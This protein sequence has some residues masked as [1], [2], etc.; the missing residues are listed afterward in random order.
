VAA[1]VINFRGG[2]DS[3]FLASGAASVVTTGG[4]FRAGYA[5]AALYIQASGNYWIGQLDGSANLFALSVFWFGARHL[6]HWSTF[7]NTFGG[8]MLEFTDSSGITRIRIRNTAGGGATPTGPYQLEK[9]NSVGVATALG[10]TFSPVWNFEALYSIFVSVNYAVAGQIDVWGAA[11]DGTS[12]VLLRSYAGDVTTDGV[13]QLAGLKL[14]CSITPGIANQ[15]GTAWSE[16][17]VTDS[18]ARSMSLATVAPVANG[19]THNFDTGAPAAANVN[20]TTLSVTTFDGSTTAGQL[21]QYTIGA[22]PAGSWTILDFAVSAVMRKGFS[23]PANA[24]L[25][26]RSGG[27]DYLTADIPLTTIFALGYQRSWATDPATGVTW[28][29]LPTN[30]GVRSAA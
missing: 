15:A 19:N 23:G 7:G 22:L 24:D 28:A 20:E 26:V 12:A 1:P 25:N 21:D 4:W 6:T 8:L 30:I 14:G 10:A 17:I 13:T 18:D 16:I 9:L 29:A 5:R 27:A 11:S 2:E 3:E